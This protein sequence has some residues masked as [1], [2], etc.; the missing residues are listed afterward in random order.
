MKPSDRMISLFLFHRQ[1]K[2]KIESDTTTPV[3][4]VLQILGR[5]EKLKM[6]KMH[7]IEKKA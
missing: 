2:N 4:T 3:G 7:R 6:H 1:K 5:Y